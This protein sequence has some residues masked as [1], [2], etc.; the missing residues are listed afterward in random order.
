MSFYVTLPSNSSKEDFP[1]KTVSKF[2]TK[3]KNPIRLE[4][5]YE[6]SLVEIMYPKNWKYRPDG[7]IKCFYKTINFE[8]IVEFFVY[9]TLVDLIHRINDQFKEK[10]IICEI[11]YYL[12]TQ[13]I[14]LT[15]PDGVSL[16]F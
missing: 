16:S 12:K 11:D 4:G 15:I 10:N 7:A 3:L 6:V 5:A 13:K 1:N 8:I 14:Y 2:T 9:E